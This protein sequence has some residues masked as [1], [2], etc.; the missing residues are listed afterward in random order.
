MNRRDLANLAKDGLDFGGALAGWGAGLVV[1][2]LLDRIPAQ[3]LR[4]CVGRDYDRAVKQADALADAEAETEVLDPQWHMYGPGTFEI[5]DTATLLDSTASAAVD[6]PAGVEIPPDQPP[7]PAGHPPVELVDSI[8]R[9]LFEHHPREDGGHAGYGVYCRQVDHAKHHAF[10]RTWTDWR[11]HV[12]PLIAQRIEKGTPPAG[13]ARDDLISA[14]RILSNHAELQTDSDPAFE[15]RS[16]AHRLF[17]AAD[18]H[19]YR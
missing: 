5:A 19:L 16:L 9:V 6:S 3:A 17:M 2:G 11:R 13:I 7:A 10:F 8:I 4:V 12:A 14:A 15:L 1:G 18:P